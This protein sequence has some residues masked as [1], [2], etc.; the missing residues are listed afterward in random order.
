MIKTRLT[1]KAQT[2]VVIWKYIKINK[3][4]VAVA[5]RDKVPCGLQSFGTESRSLLEWL[6]LVLQTVEQEYQWEIYT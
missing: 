3:E 2:Q 6:L 5:N 4:I 1:L